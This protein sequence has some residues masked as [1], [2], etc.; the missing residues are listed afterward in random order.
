M[1]EPE[2]QLR[3]LRFG[4]FEVDLKGIRFGPQE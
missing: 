2:H 4:N 3:L 1:A